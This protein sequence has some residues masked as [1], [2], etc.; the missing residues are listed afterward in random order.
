MNQLSA[1]QQAVEIEKRGHKFIPLLYKHFDIIICIPSDAKRNTWTGTLQFEYHIDFICKIKDKD[2]LKTVDLKVEDK[3][4]TKKEDYLGNLFIETWSNRSIYR[5]GWFYT[6]KSDLIY[7]CF[8]EDNL[9]YLFQ[10]S[11]LRKWLIQDEHIKKFNE[12]KQNKYEQSNDTWGILLPI[13][14]LINN[15][16]CSCFE[17]ENSYQQ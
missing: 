15:I 16:G 12:I 9:A 2:I 8:L 10:L 14:L 5:L 4:P 13:D 17:L 6:S 1:Y 7:Y 3:N 11:K